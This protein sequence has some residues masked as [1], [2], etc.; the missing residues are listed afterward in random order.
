MNKKNLLWL[1]SLLM[2]VQVSFVSCN[3]DDDD[4]EVSPADIKTAI[5]GT[6]KSV[7]IECYYDGVK[8]DE[9]TE[10]SDDNNYE[11]EEFKSDGTFSYSYYYND[12]KEDGSTGTWTIDG[13]KI[14][15]IYSNGEK[16]EYTVTIKG[17]TRIDTAEDVYNEQDGEH[18][19]KEV[20]TYTRQ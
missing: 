20:F 14:T 1:L 4:D 7:S 10:I 5:I 17:N 2:I 18:T 3:K 15:Y 12:V 11:L 13:S 16:E 9:E 19:Y 6:W 8:D